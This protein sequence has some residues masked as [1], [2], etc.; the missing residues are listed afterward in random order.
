MSYVTLVRC[1][2]VSESG[3]T[4]WSDP[5][6]P[7]HLLLRSLTHHHDGTVTSLQPAI[8]IS[9]TPTVCCG[10]RARDSD[11]LEGSSSSGSS[12]VLTRKGWCHKKMQ[13][14]QQ[15][16]NAHWAQCLCT[17]WPQCLC[18]LGV[19]LECTLGAVL[20]RTLATGLVRRL[21]TVLVRTLAAG[22]VCTLA[23]GLACTLAALIGLAC[24]WECQPRDHG[25]S[26]SSA[27]SLCHKAASV[28]VTI[29]N[30][31]FH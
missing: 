15:C 3:L 30:L 20:V 9:G 18:I 21:G 23:A 12:C 11:V 25:C 22:L 2:F 10:A 27:P 5:S 1:W 29:L 19:A 4:P 14:K 28:S 13:H 16:L 17:H 8:S 6:S 31:L 26:H 7:A 24:Y